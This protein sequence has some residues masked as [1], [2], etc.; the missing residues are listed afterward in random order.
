[1]K[2]IRR[3][4]REGTRRALLAALLTTMAISA[5]PAAIGQ[6]PPPGSAAD[7]SGGLLP[8]KFVVSLQLVGQFFPEIIQTVSTGRDKTAVGNPDATRAA[9]YANVDGTKLVTVT[10]DRY[11][12]AAYAAAAYQEALDKSESVPGFGPISIQLNVGQ[13]AFAGTV[14]MSGETHLGLGA[15]N[16]RLIVGAT[17]AG[18]DATPDN[19][20][21]L[22]ALARAEDAAATAAAGR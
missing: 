20:V 4:H 13:R 21:N 14:T 3:H 10:V 11:P 7:V 12:S 8:R 15:L 9:I 2:R 22:V 17:L 18:F 6:S 5:P 16:D 19:L 1:M